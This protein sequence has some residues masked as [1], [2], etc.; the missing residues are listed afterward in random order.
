LVPGEVIGDMRHTS[1]WKEAERRAAAA[2]GGH[3][4][5]NRGTATADVE[6][7]WCVCEVKSRAALPAWLKDAMRQ[8]EHVAA[9]SVTPPLP[10]VRLHEVGGRYAD[11]LIV[12][13]AAEFSAWHGELLR[14][15]D[16]NARER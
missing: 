13:R 4:N 2:I 7:D 10:L 11:D 12:M 8:V 15:G 3:R 1:T 5:G 16:G 6:S 9:A 14:A